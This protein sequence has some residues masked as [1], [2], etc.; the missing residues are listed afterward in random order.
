MCCEKWSSVVNLIDSGQQLFSYIKLYVR[1][2]RTRVK[3]SV[4]PIG[5]LDGSTIPGYRL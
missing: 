3:A 5:S 1:L 4:A 2:E